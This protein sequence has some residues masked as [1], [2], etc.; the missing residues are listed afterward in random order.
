MNGD[1]TFIENF[2]N[3][4]RKLDVRF[5]HLDIELY[6]SDSLIATQVLQ[7]FTQ[8]QRETRLVQVHMISSLVY[9][10]PISAFKLQKQS[11][12]KKTSHW[13]PESYY[14][15]NYYGTCQQNKAATLVEMD[16]MSI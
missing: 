11:L 1:F 13:T 4:N 12:I 16:T 3:P 15:S 9:L 14:I 2:T 7:P 6:F 8:K 10:P 5:E